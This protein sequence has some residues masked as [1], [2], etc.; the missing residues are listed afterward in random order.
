MPIRTYTNA[1]GDTL[2]SAEDALGCLNA[3][4]DRTY[5]WG[6]DPET[7]ETR[8]LVRLG[9]RSAWRYRVGR[10]GEAL[11]WLTLGLWGRAVLHD[12]RPGRA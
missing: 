10:V 2:L 9:E 7:G 4:D 8:P 1:D 5:L 3:H 11:D 6:L 12:P